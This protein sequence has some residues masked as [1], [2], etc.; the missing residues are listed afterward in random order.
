MILKYQSSTGQ[1]FDLKTSGIKTKAADFHRYRWTPNV[2]GRQYGAYVK[3]FNKSPI[4]YTVD[5]VITGTIPERK[6]KL[7]N[8]HEAF[9]T[10]IRSMTP[11]RIIHGEYYIDCYITVSNTWYDNPYTRD[12]ITVYCPYPFWQKPHDYHFTTEDGGSGTIEVVSPGGAEF[13][14]TIH[15]PTTPNHCY[16]TINGIN[17]GADVV[18]RDGDR[19]VFD[20]KNKTVM[21]YYDYGGV[22]NVFRA[23]FTDQGSIFE[24]ISFGEHEITWPEDFDVD[25]TITDER[26]EP[27]WI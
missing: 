14:L 2:V 21:L 12:T 25:L 4:E 15:G 7:N 9:D 20:S 13:V 6:A 18:M 17:I 8:L 27:V 3:S 26:S 10:D 1:I 16:V 19:L 24:K 11:G 22:A 23:R 5:L